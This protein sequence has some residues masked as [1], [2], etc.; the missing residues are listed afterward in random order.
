MVRDACAVRSP[1]LHDLADSRHHSSAPRSGPVA[2]LC[3]RLGWSMRGVR[4]MLTARLYTR[5]SHQHCTDWDSNSHCCHHHHFCSFF[6]D[7]SYHFWCHRPNGGGDSQ[8]LPKNVNTYF[9]L[10]SAECMHCNPLCTCRSKWHVPMWRC[11]KPGA[12]GRGLSLEHSS[13]ELVPA[14]PPQPL[15]ALLHSPQGASLRA[16]SLVLS[17]SLRMGTVEPLHDF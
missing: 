6:S 15:Y 2:V 13:S 16:P 10:R 1:L 7:H 3:L 4:T 12:K 17:I 5:P 14:S 8:G 11:C 9:C